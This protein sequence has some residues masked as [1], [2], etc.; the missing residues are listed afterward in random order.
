[1]KQGCPLSPLF[2]SIFIDPILSVIPGLQDHIICYIDDI[3]VIH[4]TKEGMT[5]AIQDIRVYLARLG[6][7]LNPLK[8]K[9]MG[10]VH[11]YVDEFGN[12]V[13][14]D[15]NPKID[16]AGNNFLMRKGCQKGMRVQCRCISRV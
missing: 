5:T 15:T 13:D 11:T 9:V 6:L 8:S 7:L 4:P 1:M 10:Y 14:P 2:F 12:L 3:A 16:P